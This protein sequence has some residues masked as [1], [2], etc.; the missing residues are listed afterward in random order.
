MTQRIENSRA[1]G[2]ARADSI[3]WAGYAAATWAFFFAATS[4]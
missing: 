2:E 1:G 4:F 3:A